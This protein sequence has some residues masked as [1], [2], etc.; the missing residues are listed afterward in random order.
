MSGHQYDTT[1]NFGLIKPWPNQ[2]EDLWGGHWNQNADAIDNLFITLSNKC[3]VGPAPDSTGR[4]ELWWDSIL[5]QLYVEYNDGNSTQFVSANSVIGLPLTGGA[6]TGPL[7]LYGNA[8]QAL[9]AV[10]LQQLN[11]SIAAAA[12][13]LPAAST[14]TRGGV[15][16][17][18]TTITVT[19]DVISSVGGGAAGGVV[20][21]NPTPPASPVVGE[22]WWD[23]TGGQ[24]YLYYNDGTSSQFVPASNNTIGGVV[25]YSQLPAGLQ[26]VPISFAFSGK[27]AAGAVLNVPT[28][29][30]L[31]VPPALAG[32]VVYDT[33]R[34]AASP[35]FT[36]N[37]IS[38]GTTT[39]LGTITINN[40]SNTSA[41]LAGAGGSLAVGDVMQIVAPTQ[42][43]SL[44]D[45]GITVRCARV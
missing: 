10:P 4:G 29:V 8:A 36:L 18:G 17:D 33:T 20:V 40:A 23:S 15:R 19:G 7:V 5:G 22:L 44:S 24:L 39:A 2:D 3:V 13:S 11:S 32:T 41:T 43:A 35:T 27:P 30:A 12:Y 9:E 34:P 31:T 25:P 28:A 45:L 1:L 26:S 42:D 16:V 6:L 14:T 21:I 37:K 38:A